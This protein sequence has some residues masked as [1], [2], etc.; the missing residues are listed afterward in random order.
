MPLNG[1]K[2]GATGVSMAMRKVALA[3]GKSHSILMDRALDLETGI[4]SLALI[5]D[6]VPGDRIVPAF[7]TSLRRSILREPGSGMRSE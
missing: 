1:G 7:V 5:P 6:T 4:Q 3:G 2:K